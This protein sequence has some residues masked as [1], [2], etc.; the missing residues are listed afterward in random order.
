MRIRLLLHDAALAVGFAL[1][2][3]AVAAAL[4]AAWGQ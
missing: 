2:V 4:V 1:V 3:Y